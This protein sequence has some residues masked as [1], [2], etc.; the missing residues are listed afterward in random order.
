MEKSHKRKYYLLNGLI[1]TLVR[2]STTDNELPDARV[3][4]VEELPGGGDDV[5]VQELA[6][7]HQH[8]RVLAAPYVQ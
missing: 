6:P 7:L 4:A 5:M 2:L 8:V 3:A 1:R